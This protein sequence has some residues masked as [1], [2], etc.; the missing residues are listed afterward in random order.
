MRTLTPAAQA[1]VAKAQGTEPIFIVEIEWD[2][3]VF[4]LYASREIEGIKGKILELGAI[5]SILT[6]DDRQSESVRLTLDDTDGEI[7]TIINTKDIQKVRCNLYQYYGDLSNIADKFQI[8]AGQISTPFL[9]GEGDRSVQFDILSEIES[10]EVGFSP[11][12]GQLEFVSEDFIGRPW[13]LGFGS[14]VHVPGTKVHQTLTGELDEDIQIVDPTLQWKIDRLGQQFNLELFLLQFF[15]MLA[16]SATLISEPITDILSNYITTIV[17]ERAALLTLVA[18]MT[19]LEEKRNELKKDPKNE[20]LLWFDVQNLELALANMAPTLHTIQQAKEALEAKVQLAEYEYQVKKACA[21]RQIE[22]YNNMLQLY[23]QIVALR[24]EICRQK[25][26]EKTCFRVKGGELF[27]QNEE[28]TVIIK[29]VKFRGTF[30]GEAFCQ[31]GPPTSKYTNLPLEEWHQDDDPCSPEDE[32]KG[33]SVFWLRD[34]PAKNLTGL[35]LL[36]KAKDSLEEGRSPNL[37]HILR[38]VRQE[39][40]KVVFELKEWGSSSDSPSGLSLDSVIQEAKELPIFP[41]SPFGGIPLDLYTGNLD[42]KLYA[43]PETEKLAAIIAN[44]P[45]GV[46]PKEFEH[47]ARMVFLEPLDNFTGLVFASPG[48]KDVFTVIGPDI[49]ELQEASGVIHERWISDNT[50]LWQELPDTFEWRA[51]TGTNVR[52]KE[53]DC[54]IYIANILPST[55]HGVYAFRRLNNGIRR[56]TPV[57]SSYYIKKESSNL[58]TIDVTALIF[59]IALRTIPGENWEDDVYITYTS[60]VGPYIVDIIQWLIETYTVGTTVNAANFAAIKTKLTNY[61][62]HFVLFDRPNVLDEIARIAWESRCAIY[63]RGTE[64]FIKYLSEEPTSDKTF[65]LDDIESTSLSVQYTA[66]EDIVTRLRAKYWRNYL[67]LEDH[68]KQPELVYRHNVKKYGLH[69]ADEFFHIYN[70]PELVEKSATFW[71]IRMANTWKV[72]NFKTFMT[73]ITMETFDTILLDIAKDFWSTEDV[74]GIIREASYNPVDKELVYSVWLPIRSGEMTPYI[75]AWPALQDAE[76]QFPTAAEIEKG[77]GGG[78]GPGTGVTGTID[79]C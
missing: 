32:M 49:L 10:Y 33:L 13:P 19:Q 62:A 27:P 21:Q 75:W 64:F 55:I 65:T 17:Q 1:E 14:P 50:I 11:E 5:E 69:D 25:K 35:W 60:T 3:G 16:D 7:K 57:P 39:G 31:T 20:G 70:I 72:L 59:P 76:S 53:D 78:Y 71:L 41:T 2:T 66:T 29:D 34:E 44:I 47:L 46:N 6:V 74:K 24:D 67:P 12:E 48:P 40:R 23:G 28:V 45:G 22:H 8:F 36:V 73:N 56:L 4:T 79:G 15:G 77:L 9:W 38:C 37:R 43:R 63:R 68:Q 30:D 26:L 42:P 52:A 18:A 61:P 58:G 51:E 54:E